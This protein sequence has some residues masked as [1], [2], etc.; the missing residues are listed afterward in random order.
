MLSTI[1]VWKMKRANKKN[2]HAC[3]C[4]ETNYGEN[5][6]DY[7]TSKPIA[8]LHARAFGLIYRLA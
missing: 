4:K 7:Q 8:P 5:T 2:V 6:G 3:V 1:T